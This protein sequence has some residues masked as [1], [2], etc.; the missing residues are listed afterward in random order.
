MAIRSVKLRR[1]ELRRLEMRWA[2]LMDLVW[3]AR[4]PSSPTRQVRGQQ[5]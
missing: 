2:G 3:P 1:L 5:G 4:S